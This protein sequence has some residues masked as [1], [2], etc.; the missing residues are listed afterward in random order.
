MLVSKYYIED[1]F[2]EELIETYGD[3]LD[4]PDCVDDGSF[5]KVTRYSSYKDAVEE[6]IS[7]YRGENFLTDEVNVDGEIYYKVSDNM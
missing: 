5:E 7:I 1:R 4:F 3:E 2:I 6:F